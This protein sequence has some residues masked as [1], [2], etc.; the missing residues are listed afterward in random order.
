MTST[1]SFCNIFSGFRDFCS[2]Q[3]AQLNEKTQKTISTTLYKHYGKRVKSS[4]QIPEVISLSHVKEDMVVKMQV[5][6]M[7]YKKR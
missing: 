7:K 5:V 3:C 6:H 4:M 1:N 2:N